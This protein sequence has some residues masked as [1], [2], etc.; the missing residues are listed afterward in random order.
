MLRVLKNKEELSTAAADIFIETAQSAIAKKG[1]FTVAL[2]G[3]TSPESVYKLLAREEYASAIDW[4]KV[5][6]FWGDERWVPLDDERS[7]AGMAYN[8][9]LKHVPIPAD[10]L[11]PMWESNREPEE[12]AQAYEG[13]L[14]DELGADGQFDLILLGMGEDGHTASL[15]PGTKVLSEQERWVVSY[16][17]ESQ[18]M[19]R[20]TFTAPLLNK[21]KRIMFMVFGA[22]KADALFEV[23]EGQPNEGVYPAQLIINESNRV[24]WLADEFAAAKLKR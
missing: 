13:L 15:F 7:N 9:L 24:I 16:Y 4:T 3:G 10:Q 22:S 8:A 1:I 2:T 20:I 5:I 14:R 17:L 11:F 19:Y 6:V 12:F 21:A 23:L 18:Q